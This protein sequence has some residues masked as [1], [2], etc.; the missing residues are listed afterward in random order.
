[1][2][3]TAEIA[4]FAADL[5]FED[6][7]P[8]VVRLAKRQILGLLGAAYAGARTGAVQTV[9]RALGRAAEPATGDP[10]TTDLASLRATQLVTGKTTSLEDAAYLN[11]CASMAFDVDDYVV[12][13]HAGH[14][15]VFGSLAVGQA[16]GRSGKD[17]LAA[18]VAANE[19]GGRLGGSCLLGPQNGQLW[20]Y[21]HQLGGA[22]AA[23]RLL[24]LDPRGVRHAIGIALAQPAFGLWPAFMGPDAKLVTAAEPLRNGLRAAFLANAGLTGPAEILD[25]PTGL[26]GMI[27]FVPL[28]GFFTGLGRAWL[29]ETL[30][31]K[32]T[33]GC[34]YVTSA[35]VAMQQALALLRKQRGGKLEPDDVEKIHVRATLLTIEMDKL[36]RAYVAAVAAG[37]ASAPTLTPVVVNF[38]TPLSLALALLDDGELSPAG[39]AE[40][41]L[42]RDQDV[43]LR[44]ARRVVVEHDADR[45]ATLITECDRVL[46]LAGLLE[47]VPFGD[48]ASGANAMRAEGSFA[49]TLSSA[50]DVVKS[51]GPGG[52][53]LAKR[54]VERRAS[55]AIE[56]I[57]R[58]VTRALDEFIPSGDQDHPRPKVEP[59]RRYDLAGRPLGSFRAAFGASVE[60]RDR[61]G[62][63]AEARCEVPP[64]AA[65]RDD[66]ETDRLVSAKFH[67]HADPV[68]GSEHAARMERLILALEDEKDLRALT[69][70]LGR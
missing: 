61:D 24:G 35:V 39:L 44:F 27:P 36:S 55:R 9:A 13:G 48:L 21:V 16:L 60:L 2:T 31:V 43:I 62:N 40:E 64:G 14:S 1:V 10:A 4:R 25:A 28:P 53:Q 56:R 20:S 59:L 23:A 57:G 22:A 17:V 33:P 45:T 67:R 52:R 11:A 26:L 8:R 5:R 19:L 7:P 51:L 29:T 46:D 69:E 15:A 37:G 58:S 32:L 47:G 68:I 6:I 38:S 3:T 54:L 50:L 65:G 66:D 63:V 30:S 42:A 18:L 12:F 70:T 34:A 49:G 41:R